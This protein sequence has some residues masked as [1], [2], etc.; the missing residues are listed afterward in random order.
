MATRGQWI[1]YFAYRGLAAVLQGTPRRAAGALASVA[2]LAV[3][4][5]WRDKRPLVRANLRRVLGPG[6]D[7]A[8]IDRLVTKAFCS[9]ARYWVESARVVALRSDQIESTFSIDGFERFR[10]EMARGRG[11]V[12]VLPHVGSW[13]YG[14]R[15]LAQQGYPMTTVGELLEPPEL[16]EWFTSQRAALGLNVLPPGHDTTVRLL[17]TLRA[18]RVVGLL[19]DRDLAGNGVEVEFFGDKTTLPAGPALLALRSGAPL[20]TCAIYQQPRDLYHAVLQAPLDSTRTGQLRQDV[21]RLTEEMARS[22]EDLIRLAPEQWHLFQPNWP[23]DRKKY[24]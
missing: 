11:V 1:G 20:M 18:G 15:W 7:E 3:S 8:A 16:F 12:I 4:E 10:L 23:S 14:G 19:A 22:L 24:G 17:D 9:Y 21:Q 13:E 6:M 2:G 5:V